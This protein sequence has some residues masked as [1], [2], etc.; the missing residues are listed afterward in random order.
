F[1]NR[2]QMWVEELNFDKIQQGVLQ[3]RKVFNHAPQSIQGIA[4]NTR[5]PPYDD[6]RLRKALRYLFNRELMIEK[7]MFNQYVLMDSFYPFTPYENPADEK[8]RYDRQKAVQLL[9]EAGWKDHDSSGRL[10]K[11]GQP[12]N[13]ELVYYD[14]GSERFYTPWQEDLRKVGIN[15]NL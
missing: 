12:S 10:V 14:K 4:F 1:V 7:L 13:L 9:A 11:N 5:R 8:I 3:K 6:M 2:A 15:L